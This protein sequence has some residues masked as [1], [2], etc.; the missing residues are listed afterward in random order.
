[1]ARKTRKNGNRRTLR[2]E[3]WPLVLTASLCLWET[4]ARALPVGRIKNLKP[5]VQA[6]SEKESK[7]EVAR[8]RRSLAFGDSIKT[9][10]TGKADLLFNN[11]TQL[12]M[13]SNCQLQV[14]APRSSN[15]PL[16]ISV[17]GALSEVFVR[18]KSNTEI[19]TAAGTAAVRGTQYLIQLLDDQTTMVTVVEGSVSFFNPQGSVV[20][21][22][23]QQSRARVGEA[24]TP[25]VAVDV[26][27]LMEWTA[28]I[29]GLPVEFETPE[30]LAP[31][32]QAALTDLSAG[33][34]AEA[35]AAVAN[36]P[37]DA[38]ALA[39]LGLVE[40]HSGNTAQATQALQNAVAR[41]PQ[42]YQAQALL[43]L[44]YLSL[45]QLPEAEQA[46][47]RAAGLQ[48]NSA[49]AQGT[50]AMVLFFQNRPREATVAAGR[51]VKLNPLSP[52]ALLT[53]G[54]VLL[55]QQNTDAALSS[56][57]QATAL[58]PGLAIMQTE[59][60]AAY[61]RLD[62]PQHAEK[63]YQESLQLNPDSAAA[64]TGLGR[65][66]QAQGRTQEARGEHE[67]AL[68]LDPANSQAHGNLAALLIEEGRLQEAQDELEQG[69]KDNPERG[70]YYVWLSELMLYK[71]NLPAAQKFAQKAVRLLPKSAPAH[72][73][74]GRVYLE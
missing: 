10:P 3:L 18:A 54:R 16:V 64:H 24:P 25:P 8:E 39:V 2:I 46:A 5:V 49:Q 56:F 29:V 70:S 21:A 69:V 35:R 27:G 51:A 71:Q 31:G 63:A 45:N 4:P 50:L 73:Q 12:A 53:Q 17:F 14:E 6:K 72:Y 58:A 66:L 11:G 67:R 61:L 9:G 41:D 26:S 19:R 52:F 37:D 1:M 48:P 44:T 68:Q 7:W 15:K 60:G 43:A 74:L 28:D 33:R 40:L 59:L 55:S 36:L 62:R 57:Q 30:S 47:Q 23:N 34:A 13:R 22:A 32:V 38:T 65:A 42:L 20:V